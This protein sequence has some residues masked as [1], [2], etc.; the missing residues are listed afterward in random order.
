[1]TDALTPAAV[2]GGFRY[3]A[4][5][6][7]Y[8]HTCAITTDGAAQCWG[9]NA[10]GQLGDGSFTSSL[11]PVPVSGGLVW[12]SISAGDTFSCGVTTAGVLYCWGD[13]VYGQLGAAGG[14]S[15]EPVK[16]P[17]QP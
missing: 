12:Q 16:L 11:A 17:F 6:A 10:L 13:N 15:P 9:D 14:A 8:R 5:S 4:I 7:G 3:R 2:V 1:M